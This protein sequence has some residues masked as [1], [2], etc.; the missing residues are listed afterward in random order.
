MFMSL[1]LITLI[2]MALYGAVL[3][4]EAVCVVGDARQE[5]A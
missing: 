1:I 4:L 2:G 3:A 5:D